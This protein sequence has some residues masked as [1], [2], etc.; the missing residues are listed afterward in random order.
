MLMSMCPTTKEMNGV[1]AELS[2]HSIT[3]YQFWRRRPQQ[4]KS[5]Q[6][7]VDNYF[8]IRIH[9]VYVCTFPVEFNHHLFDW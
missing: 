7:K 9:I 6:N 8:S 2:N 1:G 4:Q 5:S 3:N